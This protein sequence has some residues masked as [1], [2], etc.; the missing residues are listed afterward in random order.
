KPELIRQAEEAAKGKTEELQRPAQFSEQVSL[1]FGLVA[2]LSVEAQRL[3]WELSLKLR[4]KEGLVRHG[5][6][7][8]T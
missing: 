2:F 5:V 1:S 3:G 7:V 4:V 8:Y 6:D